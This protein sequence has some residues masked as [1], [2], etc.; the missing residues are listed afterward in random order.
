MPIEGDPHELDD[1]EPP[2]READHSGARW[3]LAVGLCLL[4]LGVALVL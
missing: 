2:A 4:T 1:R 3:M